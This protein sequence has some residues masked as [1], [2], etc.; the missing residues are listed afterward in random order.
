ML[1]DGRPHDRDGY[2]DED[3]AVEDSRRA[4]AEA[5][6]SG[7]TPYCITVDPEEPQEYM[8]HIFGENGYRALAETAHLPEVLLRAVQGLLRR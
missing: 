2:V 6:A 7:V 8:A 1:S 5:R 3:Y 4:V